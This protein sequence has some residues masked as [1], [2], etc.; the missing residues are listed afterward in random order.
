M[1]SE[2]VELFLACCIAC[3]ISCSE[4]VTCVFSSFFIF[5]SMTVIVHRIVFV[6]LVNCLLKR[7][8]L[9]ASV[10]AWKLLNLIELL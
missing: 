4:I 5:L 2:P 7:W 1:S 6:V 8:A 3:F 9:S 10:V